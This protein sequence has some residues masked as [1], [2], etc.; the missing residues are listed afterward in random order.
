MYNNTIRMIKL[1]FTLFLSLCIAPL[2]S[3][4]EINYTESNED[5]SNPDRGFYYPY[6]TTTSDF[7]ALNLT[8]LVSRRNVAYEPFIANYTVKSSIALRHYVMDSYRGIDSLESSFLNA[9]QTDFDTART[10]G[11]RLIV[12][13]SYNASPVS[14]DCSAGFICPPYLDAPKSL[15][16]IHI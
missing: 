11:V 14:G 9:I 8:D 7:T 1:I 10:A 5:I 4:I 16:L 15:S 3:A 12:R 2:V 6:T 13:F